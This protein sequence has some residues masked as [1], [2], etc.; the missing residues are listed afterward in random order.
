M[1][2]VRQS[3]MLKNINHKAARAQSDI[4]RQPL[5]P[6]TQ[7][8]QLRDEQQILT[9]EKLNGTCVKFLLDK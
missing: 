4:F 7:S 5:S 8:H 1:F 6:N 9:L 2:L 3:K